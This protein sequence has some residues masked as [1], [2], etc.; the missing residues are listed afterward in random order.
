[1]AGLRGVAD[2]YPGRLL[3]GEIY[4]PIERLVR[5]YG[6]DG[7]GLHLPFNF[8]LV[9]TTWEAPAIRA[10]L[11]DYE[12][13]LPAGACP[14]WVLGNHDQSR[15][16]TRVGPAQARVAAM[17]LLTLRGTV[18]LYYG[19]ELG[20]DDVEIP[21]ERVVDVAGRDPARTPMP[22]S[23]GTGAGFTAGEPWLPIGHSA[24][25]RTVAR[26]REDPASTLA[27]HRRLIALR[28]AEP[29]LAIGAWASVDAPDGVVAFDRTHEG[30]SV[31]VLLNLTASAATVPGHDG[32]R[33]A[34]STGLD[35]DGEAVGAEV[36]LR[37]DEGIVIAPPG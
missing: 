27:L 26:L 35:R 33:I 30:R 28:R 32:W 14:S 34:C 8:G 9:T 11:E 21:A 25:T 16:A 23:S 18:T 5:Y 3:I 22:W 37:G 13:A 4:L 6:P 31:R 24:A 36:G 29:P 7:R 10:L 15:V 1:M 20:L 12:R 17:L 19:D 2:A